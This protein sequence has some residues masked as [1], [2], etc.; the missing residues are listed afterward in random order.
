MVKAVLPQGIAFS[1]LLYSLD[2]NG[3]CLVGW[4]SPP[5]AQ[6]PPELENG[7]A[8]ATAHDQGFVLLK[9]GT[10]SGWGIQ[11]YYFTVPESATNAVALAAGPSGAIIARA[12]GSV[13]A[14]GQHAIFRQAPESATNIVRVAA[15][16]KFAAGLRTDGTVLT[17]GEWYVDGAYTA[18]V[19]PGDLTDVMEL[20]AGN[21]HLMCLMSNGTVRCF[22]ANGW[23]QS[24]VPQDL[25]SVKAISACGHNSL[26]L[27]ADGKVIGWGKIWSPAE[28]LWTAVRSIGAGVEHAVAI[29]SNGMVSCRGAYVGG[30]LPVPPSDL[31]NAVA[32]AGG[33]TFTIA[34]VQSCPAPVVP[35]P[36]AVPGTNVCAGTAVSLSVSASGGSEPCTFQW[37]RN[38]AVIE[39]ATTSAWMVADPVTGDSYHCEVASA[40]GAMNASPAVILT[41]TPPAAAPDYHVARLA[42]ITGTLRVVDE[43][44]TAAGLAV[45]GVSGGTDQ[46]SIWFDGPNVLFSSTATNAL[47]AMS[48]TVGTGA[49]MATGAIDVFFVSPGGIAR[50]VDKTA[51]GLVIEFAGEPGAVYELQKASTAEFTTHDQVRTI[52]MPE[53]GI[54]R[55]VIEELSGAAAFYRLAR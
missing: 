54:Y 29:L 28:P 46:T 17:W 10:V 3:G 41:V 51:E 32:V 34:L 13:V 45:T 53:D 16:E 35:A 50:T 30:S 15:G 7:L 43:T 9:D 33:S 42:G 19:L 25:A 52:M 39:G 31:T 22:G 55:V 12:D 36:V 1:L 48:Y 2:L 47:V 4:G 37:W 24:D 11:S 23:A 40:C 18:P 6:V 27:Q 8:I 5:G 14:W 20:S 44:A 49:C 26:A 21:D 38:G